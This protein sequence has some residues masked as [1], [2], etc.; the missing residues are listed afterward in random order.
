M[1]FGVQCLDVKQSSNV[2]VNLVNLKVTR[3]PIKSAVFNYFFCPPLIN[4]GVQ[5]FV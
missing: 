1:T 4:F 3:N 2:I 5:L